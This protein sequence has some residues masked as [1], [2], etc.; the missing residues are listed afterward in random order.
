MI[1]VLET[2]HQ[3]NPDQ[4]RSSFVFAINFFKNLFSRVPKFMRTI[5]DATY[6][7]WVNAFYKWRAFSHP[8]GVLQEM[9]ASAEVCERGF[10]RLY[11]RN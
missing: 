11:G 7:A 3:V 6:G 9:Q 4:L 5:P 1:N 8:C 2:A 10:V